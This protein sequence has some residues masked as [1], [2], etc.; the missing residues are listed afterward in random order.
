[1]GYGAPRLCDALRADQA[2]LLDY[3]QC[4]P[5]V[6][7]YSLFDGTETRLSAFRDALVSHRYVDPEERFPGL[8]DTIDCRF[9]N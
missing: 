4:S 2:R 9:A 7:P 6:R 3:R 1:M 8:V 5:A